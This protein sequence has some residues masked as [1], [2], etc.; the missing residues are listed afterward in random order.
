MLEKNNPLFYYLLNL[1]DEAHRFAIYNHKVLRK[2]KLFT[3]EIDMIPNVGAKRKK[4]LLLFF[5]NIEELKKTSLDRLCKVA[6]ISKQTGIQILNFF[7]K[8]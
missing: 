2:N 1:R 7:D 8:N 5:K 6:G 3:S 4:N